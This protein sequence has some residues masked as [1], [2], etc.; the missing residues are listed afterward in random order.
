[1]NK[2]EQQQLLKLTPKEFF[3]WL[4]GKKFDPAT[5]AKLLKWYN[6]NH[7]KGLIEEVFDAGE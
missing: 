6:D 1:M 4:S 7:I 3:K 2:S 5:W